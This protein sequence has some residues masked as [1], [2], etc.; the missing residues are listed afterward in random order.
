MRRIN[1]GKTRR[2]SRRNDAGEYEQSYE[3]GSEDA[4]EDG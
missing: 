2:F 1:D 3:A 4:A